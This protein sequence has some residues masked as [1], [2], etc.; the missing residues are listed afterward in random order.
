MILWGVIGYY[1]KIKEVLPNFHEC[2]VV[3]LLKL[4][5]FFSF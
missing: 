4:I 2:L 5:K 3:W 1:I